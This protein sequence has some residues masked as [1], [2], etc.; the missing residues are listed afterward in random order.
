MLA[1]CSLLSVAA[2]LT[3][4]AA[5][6]VECYD[7]NPTYKAEK[8]SNYGYTNYGLFMG[9]TMIV[10]AFGSMYFAYKSDSGSA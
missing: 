3:A 5:I 8:Q 7:K 6:S 1:A 4:L 2:A 10:I 9:V